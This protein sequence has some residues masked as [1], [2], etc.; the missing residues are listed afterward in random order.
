MKLEVNQNQRI[1]VVTNST[2]NS[3]AGNIEH[4]LQ[5]V[6]EYQLNEGYFTVFE[7]WNGKPKRVTKA[8]LKRLL[9]A[10]NLEAI[11]Y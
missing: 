8:G 4:I 2:G 1:F 7:Y 10:N 6:N 3:F 9:K 5:I 11:N